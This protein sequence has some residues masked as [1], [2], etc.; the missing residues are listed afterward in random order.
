MARE[1]PWPFRGVLS[2]RSFLNCGNLA[3][4]EQFRRNVDNLTVAAL[5]ADCQDRFR[6]D[7]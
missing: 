3:V 4:T 5:P 7:P 6:I 1:A 2:V